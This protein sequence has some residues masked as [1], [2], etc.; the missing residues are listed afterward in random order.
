MAATAGPDV[1]RA[2]TDGPL[3]GTAAV[4]RA[5][6]QLDPLMSA[7]AGLTPW[8]ILTLAGLAAGVAIGSLAAPAASLTVLA[9]LGTAGFAALLALRLY[10][11][12]CVVNPLT[13]DQPTAPSPAAGPSGAGPRNT[14]LPRYTVLVTLYD[15]ASVVPRLVRSLD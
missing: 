3:P 12:W 7:R 9:L 14:E 5:F 8:Q 10:T 13:E 11:L 2:S 15:E 1:L 6:S 4:D